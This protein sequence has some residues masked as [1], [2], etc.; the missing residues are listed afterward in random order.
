MKDVNRPL[1][2]L[3]V[4]KKKNVLVILNDGKQF[5]G[6]LVAFDIHINIILS[7]AS[8][9]VDGEHTTKYGQVFLRGDAVQ[10]IS[11]VAA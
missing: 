9:I 7:N 4:S 2:L 6:E 3:N 11:P 8:E 1:D 10:I 5:S